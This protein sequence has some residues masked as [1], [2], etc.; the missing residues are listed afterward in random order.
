[1][2]LSFDWRT[3][4]TEKG[5]TPS[6]GTQTLGISIPWLLTAALLCMLPQPSSQM[7]KLRLRRI[8]MTPRDSNSEEE[9]TLNTELTLWH[10]ETWRIALR[11]SPG[12]ATLTALVW[13]PAILKQC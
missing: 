8:Q 6:A 7:R 13:R 2:T 12:S 11:V 1:M 10:T 3:G 4:S 5:N 9:G